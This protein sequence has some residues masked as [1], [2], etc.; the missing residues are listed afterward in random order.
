MKAV[1]RKGAVVPLEPVPSD[2]EE[3]T[4]LEVAKAATPS[5]DVGAW[6]QT[7]MQLCADSLAED[8]ERMRLALEE[9]RLQAKEQM[10]LRPMLR[11][12]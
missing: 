1:L 9:H 5:L 4:P 10:R 11:C 12:S 7:M 8:E 2:W 6:A 3:G